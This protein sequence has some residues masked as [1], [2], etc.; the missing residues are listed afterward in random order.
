MF[1]FSSF[2]QKARKYSLTQQL[3]PNVARSLWTSLTPQKYE[4]T[5]IKVKRP[6]VE[7]KC[8]FVSHHQNEGWNHT[9]KIANKFFEDVMTFKY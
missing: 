4:N 8:I 5:V 7:T 3:Y 9:V 6:Y 1:T 2:F